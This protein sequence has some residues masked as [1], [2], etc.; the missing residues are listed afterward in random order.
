MDKGKFPYADVPGHAVF[1]LLPYWEGQARPN[2]VEL[3]ADPTLR[4][5][6]ER[7]GGHTG[8]ILDPLKGEFHP[9]SLLAYATKDPDRL[10]LCITWKF[11]SD[12]PLLEDEIRRRLAPFKVG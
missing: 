1:E 11:K 6:R 3:G 8:E 7:L 2:N 5:W 10:R 12:S 9:V 4:D